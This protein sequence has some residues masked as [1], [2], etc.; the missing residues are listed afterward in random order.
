MF[1]PFFSSRCQPSAAPLRVA[2][3]LS[4]G[5]DS[6]L[7]LQLLLNAGHTVKAY[8]LQIWFQE[9]FRNYWSECPWEEDLQYCQAVCD[10]L[11]VPLEVVPLT[12]QYWDKVVTHCI[13]EV[14]AGRTPNPDVW[15][16]SRVKFGAFMEYL[17][18]QA[19][20]KWDYI[21]SGHYARIEHH[22][23][24]GFS[25]LALTPDSIKDQT[26]FLAHLTQHQL[27]KV[28]FPLGWLTKA[29]VRN[30]A[31]AA[32]LPNQDRK[33]S[34][35]ICFLGKVKFGEFIETHLG[36]WPGPLIEE[37]TDQVVGYHR[38]FWFHTIGQ[39]KGIQLS[40]GPWYVSRKDPTMN[41]VYVS[42]Q[43][44]HQLMDDQPRLKLLHSSFYCE[45]LHWTS[46]VRPSELHPL[47]CKVR[48]GP[49]MYRCLHVAYGT[50]DDVMITI[51]G[52][53]QGLAPGQYAVFYQE[54]YCLGCGV[55]SDEEGV[56]RRFKESSVIHY[57]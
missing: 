40:G 10:K 5:V 21:A 25:R 31:A 43:S 26:Y 1:P 7:A 35:G 39:R 54:G 38:G 6:S 50:G 57:T 11:N 30:L 19:A 22:E 14:Q 27:S 17:E 42:R 34:Q 56:G 44:S 12:E 45:K 41:A 20:G 24:E 51:D 28:L 29:Q 8:Y 55:I 18:T 33:D 32:S 9:D 4:G 15:C 16:N 53:D 36:S 37:E 49:N 47:Y 23:Q 48:H 46:S 52:I 13:E 2:V 3:L